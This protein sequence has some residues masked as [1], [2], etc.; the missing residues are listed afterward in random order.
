MRPLI[1]EVK[2]AL[3]DANAIVICLNKSDLQRCGQF[4][5]DF[6]AFELKTTLDLADLG[7]PVIVLIHKTQEKTPMLPQRT[8]VGMDQLHNGLGSRLKDRLQNFRRF[9]IYFGAPDDNFDSIMDR[10]C[11]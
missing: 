1:D 6:F 8:I 7:K 4:E 2:K 5:D 11:A 9:E 3:E 10:I